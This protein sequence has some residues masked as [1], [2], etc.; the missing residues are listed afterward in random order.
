MHPLFLFLVFSSFEH[1]KNLLIMGPNNSKLSP[2]KCE[3]IIFN[4]EKYCQNLVFILK[5]TKFD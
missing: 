5:N 3:F 2:L 1:A 4:Y